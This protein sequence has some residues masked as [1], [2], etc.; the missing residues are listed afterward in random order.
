MCLWSKSRK[1]RQSIF[2]ASTSLAETINPR[3]SLSWTIEISCHQVCRPWSPSHRGYPR[4]SQTAKETKETWRPTEKEVKIPRQD[5]DLSEA[6]I[7]N[8]FPEG[9]TGYLKGIGNPPPPPP[10]DSKD[11]G[12]HSNSKKAKVTEKRDLPFSNQTV[13]KTIMLQAN[14]KTLG[15]IFLHNCLLMFTSGDSALKLMDWCN[16]TGDKFVKCV[17]HVE[18]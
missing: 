11:T 7:S 6:E 4:K 17:Y 15:T 1:R 9:R 10:A 16:V 12:E 18:S 8:V 14:F 2:S 3:S 13:L 5:T